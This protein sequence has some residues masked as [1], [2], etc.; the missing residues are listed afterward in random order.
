MWGRIKALIVK[1]MLAVWRDPKS[2]F[3]L[4]VPPLVQLAVFSYACTYDVKNAALAVLNQDGGLA[5]RELV[6]AVGGSP[7]FGDLIAVDTE[8]EMAAALDSRRV[9]AALRI[10]QDF[11]RHLAAGG[12]AS[13]QI[14][15]DGRR[16][17]SAQI[18]SGY[19]QTI[20]DERNRALAGQQPAEATVAPILVTRAW[21]NPNL[22]SL[23]VVVPGL[24]G[25]LTQVV[26]LV[27]TALSVARERELGT[28]EQL[29]VT[30]LRPWEILIGKTMPAL[31]IGLA[32]STVI[33]LAAQVW[34]QVPMT[35]PLAM[36][37]GAV[38]AFVLSV[39]GVGLFISALAATQ[40]QAILGAFLYM[41][42]TIILSGFATPVE[43][44]P[45]WLQMLTQANPV[46]HFL[47]LIW[48]LF[49]KGI[50]PA[51]AWASVWPMLVIAAIT[52]AG[53]A[54]AFRRRLY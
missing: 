43:N 52:L 8:E 27:V 20:L 46:R 22:E 28:F 10:P 48:G 15:L 1:E 6:A 50:G 36:I 51:E 4:I 45:D 12:G 38:V 44:M 21:F 16:S 37:Y 26:A 18:V 40:Q 5:A 13:V 23:W 7:T 42:P 30:P 54:W 53:S 41:V 31:L 9:M 49:L 29:L 33:I 47:A 32:E 25:V 39:I 35:A 14:V 2:R 11:S 3:V 24:V 19:L 17:N 34:F